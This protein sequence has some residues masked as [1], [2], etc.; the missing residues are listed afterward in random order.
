M[1][2]FGFIM[3]ITKLYLQIVLLICYRVMVMDGKQSELGIIYIDGLNLNEKGY[4]FNTKTINQSY[5]ASLIVMT[6][7]RSRGVHY[8]SSNVT[9]RKLSFVGFVE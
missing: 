9:S 5:L 3:H 7:L 2:V 6:P 1:I 8:D 4:L